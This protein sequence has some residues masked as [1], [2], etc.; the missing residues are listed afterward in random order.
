VTWEPSASCEPG[1]WA[2]TG[3]PAKALPREPRPYGVGA[4]GVGMYER[5]PPVEWA[6]RPAPCLPGT[7]A[8]AA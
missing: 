1:V 4:Y 6:R 8:A 3:I 2:A 5:Y 7:W